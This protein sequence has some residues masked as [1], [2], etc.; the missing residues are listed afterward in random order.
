MCVKVKRNLIQPSSQ[1]LKVNLNRGMTGDDRDNLPSRKV[2]KSTNLHRASGGLAALVRASRLRNV[3]YRD[4]SRVSSLRVKG[5]KHKLLRI[6]R[7]CGVI[8][9]P[10]IWSDPPD[11][12]P[13]G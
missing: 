12:F 13:R 5:R 7:P 4:S 9:I 11:R 1:R 10:P 8:S 2:A 6:R 3:D